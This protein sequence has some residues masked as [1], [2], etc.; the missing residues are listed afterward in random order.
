VSTGWEDRAAAF[1]AWARAP[2]H[3]AYWDFREFFFEV[4]P[5]PG[6]AA[7][8]IGCGEGRVCRDLRQRGYVTIGLDA[9]PSLVAAAQQADAAGDYVVGQA[10]ELPFADGSF[11]LAVA[12]N[13]LMDVEDMPAAIAEGARVLEPGGRFCACVTHP[14]RDAGA[15]ATRV[16]GAPFVVAGSYFEEGSYELT[17]ERGGHSFTFASRTYPLD[18]YARALERAGLAIEAL[19]EPRGFDDRD[20]RM[21]QFLLWRAVKV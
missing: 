16:D 19:R 8:E 15:F 17:A 14:F 6:R 13:S 21:P 7:I 4:L 10:E 1:V 9:S 20:R 5:L 3:D 2:G 12:Y 18:S 11:D